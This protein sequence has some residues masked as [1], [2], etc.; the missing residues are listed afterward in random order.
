MGFVQQSQVNPSWDLCN[1]AINGLKI[2]KTALAM[3]RGLIL[4][5][6]HMQAL[7][8]K[9]THTL[10]HLDSTKAHPGCIFDIITTINW[11]KVPIS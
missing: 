2:L 8:D 6:L 7:I 1:K 11:P 5:Q 3:T 10:T 9:L 4:S